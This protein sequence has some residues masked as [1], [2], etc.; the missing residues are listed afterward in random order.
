MPIAIA[1]FPIFFSFMWH[2]FMIAGQPFCS[3]PLN[4]DFVDCFL[5]NRFRLNIF[6][7]YSIC[8]LLSMLS[9]QAYM[10]LITGEFWSLVLSTR[11]LYFRVTRGIILW[12]YVALITFITHIVSQNKNGSYWNFIFRIIS[13][14]FYWVSTMLC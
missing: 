6:Q 7:E 13:T 10:T 3:M 9:H 4:L 14:N 12:Q 5:L 1:Q 8:D 11:V 2:F